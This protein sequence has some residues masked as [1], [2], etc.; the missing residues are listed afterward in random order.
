[1]CPQP[2]L[3]TRVP[4]GQ[5]LPGRT[6]VLVIGWHV[7]EILLAKTPLGLTI[8]DLRCPTLGRQ[9][10]LTGKLEWIAELPQSARSGSPSPCLKSI[11][12]RLFWTVSP[13]N[14]RPTKCCRTTIRRPPKCPHENRE[15]AKFCEGCGGKFVR[16]CLSNAAC[17][18][19]ASR[20]TRPSRQRTYRDGFSRLTG[21]RRW[22]PKFSK[23]KLRQLA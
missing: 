18:R 6:A 13:R 5:T 4:V 21:C 8:R 3:K 1:M 23:S 12:Q 2:A 11:V 15:G 7:D 10:Q 22:S 9:C 17:C 19:G 16:E 20:S 14:R